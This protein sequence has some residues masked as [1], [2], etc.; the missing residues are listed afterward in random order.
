MPNWYVENDCTSILW[1]LAVHKHNN[2]G[3]VFTTEVQYVH[4][5]LVVRLKPSE[6]CVFKRILLALG[7]AAGA[8]V[9]CNKTITDSLSMLFLLWQRNTCLLFILLTTEPRVPRTCAKDMVSDN[10]LKP[11]R[12]LKRIN[13]IKWLSW[14]CIH[15]G[16]VALG[17]T[18]AGG[19]DDGS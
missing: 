5:H 19:H 15:P 17:S 6:V 18:R 10:K 8:V 3:I 9:F 13:Q 2:S 12:F 4:E 7:I 16:Q 11:P 14:K 1:V